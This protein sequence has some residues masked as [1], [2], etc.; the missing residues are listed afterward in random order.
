MKIRIKSKVKVLQVGRLLRRICK[1][2]FECSFSVLELNKRNEK[3][4]IGIPCQGFVNFIH[5]KK[6]LMLKRKEERYNKL[7][8]R[9]EQAKRE[10]R[11]NL[12]R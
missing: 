9:R 11:T 8:E 4:R 3:Y 2:M 12:K 7:K 10:V 6:K 1:A 5:K